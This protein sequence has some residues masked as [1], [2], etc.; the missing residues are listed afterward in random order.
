MSA[1]I[2]VSLDNRIEEAVKFQEILTKYG[3]IIRTRIGLHNIGE[4]KCLNNGII[5]LEVTDKINEIYDTL[6]KEWNVQIM[7][8]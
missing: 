4:Y 8:F 7:R 3:C 1:I 6:A 5:L 2:G